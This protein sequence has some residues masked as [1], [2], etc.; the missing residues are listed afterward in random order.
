M[1]SQPR[2]PHDGAADADGVRVVAASGVGRVVR[3]FAVA[4]GV[5]TA[6][7]LLAIV[8]IRLAPRADVPR[9]VASEPQ[10]PDAPAAAP[11]PGGRAVSAPAPSALAPGTLIAAAE[12]LSGPEAKKRVKEMQKDAPPGILDML[13]NVEIGEPGTGMEAFP[14]PGTKPLKRGIVVPDDYVLPPGYVRHYQTTD[15][16]K[17]LPPVLMFHP[18]YQ[19]VDK[20][21][22]PI[23]LPAD[24]VV[25]PEMAPAGMPVKTLD[26]PAPRGAA[27]P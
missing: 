15:D 16:G 5:V 9:A 14:P 19:P 23:P 20:D 27:K 24:R 6:L 25:P 12:R 18:D 7:A 22:K 1:T 13:Q 8:A 4:A 21:G 3:V 2:A 10:V 17:Q 26:L 11:V